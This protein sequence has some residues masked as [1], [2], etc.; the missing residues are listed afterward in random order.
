MKLHRL[1]L[2]ILAIPSLC[3]A[4]APDTVFLEELTWT[5]VRELIDD[6]TDTIIIPT[7]GTEQNGPHIV[8]GKH[9]Y[10]M[11]A[12][13]EAIARKLGRTLV[14][15][16]IVH[17]PEGDIEPPS[18]HMVY[19]GTISIPD[20]VFQSLVEYTARSLK[21]H[22]F[23]RVLLI[24]DSGGNQS[25]MHAV[26]KKLSAEWANDSVSV[27][28]VSAWYEDPGYRNWLSSQGFSDAQIG[29]HAGLMDTATLL[30]VAPEH[31]RLERMEAG[32]GF[33]IDG[34][35]GDATLATSDL[36]QTGFEMAVDA[37]ID[38]IK[39]AFSE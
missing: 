30:Y 5:E 1:L 28:H 25:G 37:S 7:A 8:L 10:R 39:A 17:V 21:A 38:Q 27:F 29:R 22:G 18:G 13:A 26:A 23:K 11:N 24:G 14:A 15:P 16:V 31:V 34:V 36:G 3:I 33:E 2:I 20:D 19:A 12:G 32:K 35:I 9:K 4:E 6:G